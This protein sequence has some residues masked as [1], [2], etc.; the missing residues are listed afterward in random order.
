MTGIMPSSVQSRITN[1]LREWDAN[2]EHRTGTDGDRLTS[3]WLAS[4]IRDVGQ[5]PTIDEFPFRRRTPKECRVVLGET[6]VPGIPLF[7]CNETPPEGVTDELHPLPTREGIGVTRYAVGSRHQGNERL[8]TARRVPHPGT[9]SGLI[10]VHDGTMP[11]IALINADRFTTP[12]GPPTLQVSSESAESIYAAVAAEHEATLTVTFDTETTIASNVQTIIEGSDSHLAPLVVMTPKSAWWTCTAERGGGLVAWLECLRHLAYRQPRRTVIFTA[13]TGHELGHV[14]LDEFLVAQP[15]LATRAHAWVH[16][17]ANFAARDAQ[18]R[19]QGSSTVLLDLMQTTLSDHQIP[20]S[21]QVPL[22]VRPGGEARNIYD[23]RGQ[24]VSILA[25][26]PWFH[27]SDDR[28]E[29]SVNL[30][31]TAHACEAAVDLVS[32]LANE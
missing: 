22:D 6:A 19:I 12:Y 26:N 18:V 11:G 25:S 9:L 15:S 23:A 4:K 8:E 17:G 31:R 28:L 7:D 1:D 5:D 13:N 2:P 16:F 27:R 32:R 30:D 20:I 10:A 14:G 29:T 24:Y 3:E 21:G